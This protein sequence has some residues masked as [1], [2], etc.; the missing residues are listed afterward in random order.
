[1]TRWRRST[2]LY[3]LLVAAALVAETIYA[4]NDY[5]DLQGHALAWLIVATVIFAI[6]R[7]LTRGRSA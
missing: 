3:V 2:R 6:Y 5:A 4:V 7:G 1:M